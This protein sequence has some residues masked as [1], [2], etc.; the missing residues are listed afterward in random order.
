M[1]RIKSLI[2]YFIKNS[3]KLF[4]KPT[5]EKKRKRE[6]EREKGR[7]NIFLIFSPND[8]NPESI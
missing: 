5:K 8:S 3:Q 1:W 4:T 6:R 2:P 7:D